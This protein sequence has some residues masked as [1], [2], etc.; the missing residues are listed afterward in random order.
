MS[1]SAIF[2]RRDGLDAL[3]CND[4]SFDDTLEKI[5]ESVNSDDSSFNLFEESN[6]IAGL[7]EEENEDVEDGIVEVLGADSSITDDYDMCGHDIVDDYADDIH[8][9]GDIPANIDSMEI[10]DMIDSL[11]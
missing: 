11:M 2:S 7:L 9:M 6:R 5:D 8:D 10:G 1:F 4:P 3:L